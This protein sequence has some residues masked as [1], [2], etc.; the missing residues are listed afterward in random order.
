MALA[1]SD[2]VIFSDQ[3]KSMDTTK[4]K[5]SST[6]IG[7]FVIALAILAATTPSLASASQI[8][9]EESAIKERQLE[10]SDGKQWVARI[11]PSP[12]F[13]GGKVLVEQRLFKDGKGG[14]VY[15][16]DD[17]TPATKTYHRALCE[18]KDSV[19]SRGATTISGQ[20]AWSW[21]CTNSKADTSSSSNAP[22][23]A[24][25]SDYLFA[26]APDGNYPV[27][28]NFTS[29]GVIA[30]KSVV[31]GDMKATL[32]ID[33]GRCTTSVSEPYS[34]R[35]DGTHIAQVACLISDA[36]TVNTSMEGCIPQRCAT[37]RGF[38]NPL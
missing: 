30:F 31:A 25:S 15:R 36:R 22:I 34:T 2:K 3:R 7:K 4:F 11:I 17:Q 18:A 37:S 35:F 9:N 1:G 16:F 12:D 26:V 6:P 10:S 13:N 20:A 38:L 21:S 5:N 24:R 14:L 33:D 27:G 28:S 29:S 8:A 23:S 32:S 19:P